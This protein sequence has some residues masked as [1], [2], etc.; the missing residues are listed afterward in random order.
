MDCESVPSK[1]ENPSYIITK[2]FHGTEELHLRWAFVQFD[3]MTA[4]D[5]I[6]F[7]DT[8]MRLPRFTAIDVSSDLCAIRENVKADYGL[9][10]KAQKI[11]PD[12]S[13]YD[14]VFVPGGLGTRRLQ[15]D[16]DFMSWLKTAD[17]APYKISVCTGSLLLGAAGFLREKRATTHPSAY[18]LLTPYCREVVKSRIVR[19]GN[20]ITGG[21]VSTAI[22]LG[23]YVIE[24]LSNSTI[25]QQVQQSMD[26]PYYHTGMAGT[27]YVKD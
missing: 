24:S 27:D 9:T 14:W 15:D 19:D 23:L 11:R 25:T 17:K 1:S 18:D 26:Y 5:L 4:L 3:G 21:G 10:I 22:D 8:V 2:S 7:H 12:L 20:V 16:T 6:G 13:N